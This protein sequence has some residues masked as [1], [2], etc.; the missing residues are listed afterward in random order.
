MSYLIL[1]SL[2]L[3]GTLSSYLVDVH[4][5]A[6]I[7][8]SGLSMVVGAAVCFLHRKRFQKPQDYLFYFTCIV[9]LTTAFVNCI[10]FLGV[11]PVPRLKLYLKTFYLFSFFLLQVAIWRGASKQRLF[12]IV[13][14]LS[15][16]IFLSWYYLGVT[17]RSIPLLL[18]VLQ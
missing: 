10:T 11:T 2:F 8:E 3:A 12:L 9:M 13:I 7:R 1:G 15:S 14:L 5:P 4:D 17:L 18:F 6:L 16:N